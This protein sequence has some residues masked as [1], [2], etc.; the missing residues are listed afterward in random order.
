LHIKIYNFRTFP[1][2]T[3]DTM[4]EYNEVREGKIILYEGQPYEVM[5]SHVFRK[6]QRKP[7]NATKIKNLITGRVAEISFATSDKVEEA[8]IITRPAKYL[9]SNR[10]EIWFA[11]PKDPSKRFTLKEDIVGDKLKFIKQNTEVEQVIFTD[12]DDEEQI[13]GLKVPIK[14]DL[15]ITDAPPSIKGS[16]MTGGNKVATVETG[17]TVNVPLF[18]EAGETIR[19]NTETGEYVERVS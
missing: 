17:A 4:L 19:I 13:I 15:K 16:T 5:H 2:N 3:L 10:G 12:E 14:V 9:Y 7:V 8:D 11:D 1:A 6:Q 18:V